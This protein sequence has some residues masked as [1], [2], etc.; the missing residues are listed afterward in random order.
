LPSK[1]TPD[2]GA[3]VSLGKPFLGQCALPPVK[4]LIFT[5]GRSGNTDKKSANF[6]HEREDFAVTTGGTV[7]K[8][9]SSAIQ[10]I[11]STYF[12][13]TFSIT[14]EIRKHHPGGI[15]NLVER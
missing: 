12:I 11:S 1:I 3:P 15:G 5:N 13:G 9:I 4:L 10:D 7:N 2:I 6:A 14:V 8:V